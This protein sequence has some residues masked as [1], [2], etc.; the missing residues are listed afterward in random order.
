MKQL[1]GN[2]IEIAQSLHANFDAENANDGAKAND[3][4]QEILTIQ[5]KKGRPGDDS[6]MDNITRSMEGL[7]F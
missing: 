7:I 5:A 3:R 6:G 1:K 2:L 4:P